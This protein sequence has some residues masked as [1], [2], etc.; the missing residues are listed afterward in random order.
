MTLIITRSVLHIYILPIDWLIYESFFLCLSGDRFQRSDQWQGILGHGLKLR[1]WWWNWAMCLMLIQSIALC[2]LVLVIHIFSM[3]WTHLSIFRFQVVRLK[4]ENSK[5]IVGTLIP[6]TAMTALL[7][8]LDEGSEGKEE[9]I[10]WKPKSCRKKSQDLDKSVS[11]TSSS[12]CGP[13]AMFR[14]RKQL[15]KICKE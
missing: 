2:S 7:T 14:N 10:Y 3:I 8:A 1:T 15:T 12:L 6:N 11:Q 5:R 4:L 9:T 13:N